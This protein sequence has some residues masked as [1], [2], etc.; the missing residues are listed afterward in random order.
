[1]GVMNIFFAALFIIARKEK[2]YKLLSLLS[3]I[4]S[5]KN[6]PEHS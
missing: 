4:K 5:M 1:M 2:Q 3:E 6:F